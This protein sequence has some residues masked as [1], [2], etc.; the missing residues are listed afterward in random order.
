LR[1]KDRKDGKKGN[2][3]FLKRS[4]KN[5]T[6]MGTIARS[7][8]NLCE[9]MTAPLGQN[10]NG[11]VVELGAGDGAVTDHILK[12]LGPESKLL[13]FELNKSF[14]DELKRFHDDRVEVIFDSAEFIGDHLK[15]LGINK[16]VDFIISSLPFVVLPEEVVES[17]LHSCMEHLNENGF[18][19]QYHYSTAAKKLYTKRF[20]HVQTE[21]VLMNLPPA[22]VYKC[23]N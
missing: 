7:S 3:T 19:I 5:I 15:R 11:L 9:A 23:N 1:K 22:F 14:E 12:C 20:K 2:W 6:T 17:V 13:I 10:F 8:P 4:L 16:K 18:F 21:F